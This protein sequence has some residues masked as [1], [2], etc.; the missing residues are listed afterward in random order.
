MRSNSC[1]VR[2]N[3][4]SKILFQVIGLAQLEYVLSEKT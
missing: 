2:K 1:P 3:T 4:N